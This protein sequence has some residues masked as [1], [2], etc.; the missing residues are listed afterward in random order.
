MG[1][2]TMIR[3][4]VAYL[5]LVLASVAMAMPTSLLATATARTT[6]CPDDRVLE[7]LPANRTLA[8]QMNIQATD[9]GILPECYKKCM[10]SEDGKANVT[11]SSLTVEAW[12]YNSVDF[13][14]SQAWL[15]NYVL[16]CVKYECADNLS[17]KARRARAWWRDTCGS[18]DR[19]ST[20]KIDAGCG[21]A[22]EEETEEEKGEK[23]QEKVKEKIE[24]DEEEEESGYGLGYGYGI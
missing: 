19:K 15:N 20:P 18:W 10:K 13:V 4:L 17:G 8:E 7:P 11:L 1:S 24:E 21:K 14:N 3:L 5:V 6:L 12:C 2:I 22:Q 16:P 23:K 9:D